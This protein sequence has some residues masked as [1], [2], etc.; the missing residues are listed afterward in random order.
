MKAPHPVRGGATQQGR[1]IS[2]MSI[3]SLFR[4]NTRDVTPSRSAPYARPGSWYGSYNDAWHS[5]HPGAWQ[6]GEL[7]SGGFFKGDVWG[8][9]TLDW[10]R[11]WFA[12]N[13]M[14][15]PNNAK[16]VEPDRNPN[17]IRIG[18]LG[19]GE[20]VSIPVIIDGGAQ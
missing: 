4:R 1:S 2:K 8:S 13:G 10:D 16:H 18:N 15:M 11:D 9:S 5:A 3:F 7:Q 14:R 20:S 12:R 19:P 17:I 6:R